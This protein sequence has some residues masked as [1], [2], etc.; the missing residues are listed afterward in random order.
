[1]SRKWL[2]GRRSGYGVLVLVVGL[3]IW[4]LLPDRRVSRLTNQLRA[5]TTFQDRVQQALWKNL[6]L[7]LR[8]KFSFLE[9]R[10]YSTT[11]RRAAEQLG[12]LGPLASNAV[13]ALLS[14]I[15]NDGA[16]GYETIL[17]EFLAIGRIG[18]SARQATPQLLRWLNSPDPGRGSAQGTWHRG[19]AWALARIAPDDP[20]VVTALINAL[21]RCPVEDLFAFVD[22]DD[23]R[24]P[25][26]EGWHATLRP[27]FLPS[28]KRTLIRS[29]GKLRPQTPESLSAL[30][31]QLEH[32]EYAA[33]A[34]AADV[35][36]TL[37]PTRVQVT[38]KLIESLEHTDSEHLPNA[39]DRDAIATEWYHAFERRQAPFLGGRTASTKSMSD[40]PEKRAGVFHYVDSDPFDLVDVIFVPAQGYSGWGL[41][42]SVIRALG[43]IGPDAIDALPMLQREFQNPTNVLRFNA[44]AAAWRISGPTPEVIAT[45]EDAWRSDRDTRRLAVLR[46]RDLGIQFP[47]A[48]ALLSEALQDGSKVV[49]KQAAESLAWL[50]TNAISVLPALRA[51]ENDQ[52]ISVRFYATQAVLAVQFSNTLGQALEYAQRTKA[53]K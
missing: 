9:P 22:P 17:E 31:Y 41:R 20:Q 49:R 52:T 37:R 10:D 44:A 40:T 42:A 1:M 34:T 53:K 8:S 15:S 27:P 51:L 26:V 14:A 13:P 7:P 47:K 46:L 36:G 30:L 4:N 16:C 29:L 12:A 28:E 50:G 32:G 39:L 45:F 18:P 48:V 23:F 35:L 3:V 38:R 19:A 6:P 2:T 24:E 33:R 25:I 11:H 21:G 5:G 43:H